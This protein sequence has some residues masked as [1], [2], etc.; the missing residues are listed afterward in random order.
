MLCFAVSEI[1]KIIILVL[2][3]WKNTVIISM[4]NYD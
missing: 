1:T 2:Q 4:Y 3:I